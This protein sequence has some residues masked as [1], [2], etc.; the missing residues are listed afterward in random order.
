MIALLG[1]PSVSR[2]SRHLIISFQEQSHTT[3]VLK[4]SCQTS[5]HSGLTPHRERNHHFHHNKKGMS[6]QAENGFS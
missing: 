1:L 4:H 2:V 3:V 5:M 6:E